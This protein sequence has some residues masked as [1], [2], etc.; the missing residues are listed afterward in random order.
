MSSTSR[1]GDHQ[2]RVGRLVPAANMRLSGSQEWPRW[3]MRRVD[4]C[5]RRVPRRDRHPNAAQRVDGQGHRREGVRTFSELARTGRASR[6]GGR[7]KRVAVLGRCIVHH[8]RGA[9]RQCWLHVTVT[10]SRS[11]ELTR[12]CSGDVIHLVLHGPH[13][14]APHG[15]GPLRAVGA[16][17]ATAPWSRP[18]LLCAPPRGRWQPSDTPPP[19]VRCPSLGHGGSEPSGR[20]VA[21]SALLSVF[22]EGPAQ[23]LLQNLSGTADRQLRPDLQ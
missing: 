14:P 19:T 22:P 20:S 17:C 11:T 13:Y 6:R 23:L 16:S 8:R 9:G 3:T 5:Q 10:P 15:R 4:P 18:C 12:D 7:G 21:R 1:R 2:H